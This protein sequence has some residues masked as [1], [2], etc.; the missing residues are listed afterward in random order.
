ML[1]G[2]DPPSV[3]PQLLALGASTSAAALSGHEAPRQASREVRVLGIC[4][5]SCTGKSTLAPQL[6]AE[7]HSPVVALCADWYFKPFREFQRCT[8]T[9]NCWEL[10]SSVDMD[11]LTDDLR[12]L[13]AALAVAAVGQVPPGLSFGGRPVVN[14]ADSPA[15]LSSAPVHVVLEGHRLFDHP[16]LC[17]LLHKGIWLAADPAMLAERRFMRDGGD[18]S[19]SRALSAFRAE[20]ERHI[21]AHYL[22]VAEA[23]R[24]R[25][26]GFLLGTI[27]VAP[28]MSPAAVF[29]TALQLLSHTDASCAGSSSS[30]V[31][32][33][34]AM[35]TSSTVAPKSP[36]GALR[37][38]TAAAAAANPLD[39]LLA[40]KMGA[41]VLDDCPTWVKNSVI[42]FPSFL[43][44]EDVAKAKVEKKKANRLEYAV[45]NTSEELDEQGKPLGGRG[46]S[47][48]DNSPLPEESFLNWKV[49]WP[50]T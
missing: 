12:E 6:A 35:S 3:E 10:T 32:G 4:G 1:H 11:A 29:S 45:W 23:M 46:A 28:D 44:T 14:R 21:Y 47:T 19:E 42:L 9:Q 40:E 36:R 49:T 2:L 43:S 7:L 37:S 17:A 15:L 22:E 24:S 30:G 31:G 41:M 13:T 33:G 27:N 50:P 8:H 20:F 25:A 26:S 34:G 39:T 16:A 38:I 5:A 18:L 48:R